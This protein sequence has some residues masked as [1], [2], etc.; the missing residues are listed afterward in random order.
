MLKIDIRLNAC[1]L[2]AVMLANVGCN[3]FFEGPTLRI[4]DVVGEYHLDARS[5]R[6]LETEGMSAC[7]QEPQMILL[8]PNQLRLTCIP[9]VRSMGERQPARR[10]TEQGQWAITGLG[11]WQLHITSPSV[12]TSLFVLDTRP[13]SFEWFIGD[14]D[15][16]R[17]LTFVR[18]K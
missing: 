8:E 2:A 7:S 17:S 4:D 9:D 15:S 12:N 16:G 13:F 18:R 11:R 5:R 6:L 14:P 10:I 1:M 3:N